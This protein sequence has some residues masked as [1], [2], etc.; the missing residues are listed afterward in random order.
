[1]IDFDVYTWM[2]KNKINDALRLKT[3]RGKGVSLQGAK[4][5]SMLGS[6]IT[7][8]HAALTVVVAPQQLAISIII[9]LYRKRIDVHFV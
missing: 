3:G 4:D 6:S 8:L 1:M 7:T 2:T 9:I 5:S